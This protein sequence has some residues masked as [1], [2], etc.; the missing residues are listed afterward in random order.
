[1]YTITATAGAN[2]SIIPS[3]AVPVL[4]GASQLF[5]ILPTSGYYISSLLVDGVAVTAA[6]TY[7][8]ENVSANHSISASFVANRPPQLVLTATPQSGVAP[9]RVLFDFTGS[10]DPDGSIAK[11]EVDRTG[12][13]IFEVQST[14]SGVFYVEY[15]SAGTYQTVARVTDDCNAFSTTSVTI[16]VHG[17][18]PEADI[19]PYPANGTAPLTVTFIGTNSTAPA[20]RQIVAYEWD[21]EG[22][23]VYDRLTQAAS[24]TW[25]Y[26]EA[27]TNLATLRVTDDTGIKAEKST[28]VTVLP[29][30][31]SLPDV[32]LFASPQAG[33]LPLAVS[34]TAQLG[35]GQSSTNYYWDFDGDGQYDAR[36]STGFGSNIYTVAGMYEAKVM[37]MDANGLAGSSVV[38]VQ[39]NQA[40]TLR[41]WISTPKDNSTVS[42]TDV[43]LRAHAA[44][45]NLVAS[46]QFQ[47][48]PVS[49]NVWINLGDVIY[50]PPHS[51]ALTWDVSG[52]PRM[53]YH[54][55]AAVT[56]TAGTVVYSEVI[57]VTV[58]ATSGRNPG[59]TEEGKENGKHKKTDTFGQD[60]SASMVVYD[61]TM[62][63]VG[64]GTVDS[65]ITISVILTG[66][67]TNPVNGAAFGR[68]CVN[69]NRQV[70]IEGDP[71]LQKA[72]VII[73]PYRDDDNDGVVDGTRVKVSTLMMFWYDTETGTW[74]RCLDT[75]IYP[76]E[77][78]IKG[79]VYHLT[80]F[81][82]FGGVRETP[83][84]GDF[85]GD[86]KADP[87]IYQITTG[88]WRILLS[89]SGYRETRVILGGPD[90]RAV[91]ADYDADQKTDPGVYRDKN[92]YWF[93]YL[94]G[95]AYAPGEA[96]LGGLGCLFVP[97]DYDGDGKADPAVYQEATGVWAA[98]LSG[99]S[100]Q[101]VVAT[102][103]G[104]GYSA[105]PG[106]YD[107]DGK[108][109][110]A[111]YQEASGLW[112]I[113]MSGSGYVSAVL[114]YGG[115][116]W[117]PA[118][119]DYDGD[120]RTD[121]AIYNSSSGQWAIL[122]SNSGYSQFSFILG[123]PGYYPVPGD[124]DGAGTISPAVY[125]ETTG[126]WQVLLSGSEYAPATAT[127]G[128]QDFTPANVCR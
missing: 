22:D 26:R 32:T 98:Q 81:G 78:Y 54:L 2:G 120:G 13:G 62:V 4:Q 40:T 9:L 56:D 110:L 28:L 46:A 68:T 36:T 104:A 3:G 93:G 27:G 35:E 91:P 59:D 86:R 45:A 94:S 50:P 73:I 75:E 66:L 126:E 8:F 21:Y 15:A 92:G 114:G 14:Q 84:F 24:S 124:Y 60:E 106:D 102:F 25:T 7:T 89:G 63:L 119:S 53:D 65:N 107:G 30:P 17:T 61:G 5:T 77:K 19:D 52:L 29:S 100:Y 6:S 42:G 20:G 109:D 11:Y 23:G 108:T 117:S 103:G 57:L 43:S 39:V 16:Q 85:D 58:A 105:I 1:M 125:R 115:P 10:T 80:E 83:M 55:R 113:L 70:D 99:S 121:P 90:F 47:Y 123:G 97:S 122:M 87:A 38:T 51:Y 69:Q 18:S 111:V 101:T 33:Y 31:Y 72:V 37:A 128:G 82:L 74:K 64:L 49:S 41:A 44:P 12:D 95:S 76:D 34:F 96:S 127:F 67:N 88:L 71:A 118:P 79:T 48:K 116:G 112:N